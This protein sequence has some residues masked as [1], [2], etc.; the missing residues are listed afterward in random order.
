MYFLQSSTPEF[1]K[2]LLEAHHTDLAIAPNNKATSK[3][4]LIGAF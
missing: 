3:N 4:I 2:V 1:S